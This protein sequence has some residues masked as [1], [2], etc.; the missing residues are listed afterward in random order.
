MGARLQFHRAGAGAT[1]PAISDVTGVRHCC[2]GL[3]LAAEIG[4]IER[5][6]WWRAVSVGLAGGLGAHVAVAALWQEVAPLGACEV[7]VRDVA[8]VR[9][10]GADMGSGP[11]RRTEIGRKA[12]VQPMSGAA[13][14]PDNPVETLFLP[15][16]RRAQQGGR[17]ITEPPACREIRV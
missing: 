16:Q 2:N 6:D 11:D 5:I 10:L 3:R 4:A 15:G 1:R 12:A 13:L 17:L 8:G 14:E 7:A 9:V